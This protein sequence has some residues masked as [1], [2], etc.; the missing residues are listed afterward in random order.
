MA[1]EVL[2]GKDGGSSGSALLGRI[3]RLF[4]EEPAG[5]A[6]AAVARLKKVIL[7][8]DGANHSWASPAAMADKMKVSGVCIAVIGLGSDP[9]AKEF[10]YRTPLNT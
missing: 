3:S 9:K 10:V 8:S 7:L 6:R 5:T 1:W 4:L 2:Q